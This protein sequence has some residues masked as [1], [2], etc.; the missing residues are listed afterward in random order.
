MYTL[1][2]LAVL[3]ISVRASGLLIW[4][5]PRQVFSFHA[6]ADG[7]CQ[8]VPNQVISDLFGFGDD[9]GIGEAQLKARRVHDIV[10]AKNIW[11]RVILYKLQIVKFDSD[12]DEVAVNFIHGVTLVFYNI[13][14][15]GGITMMGHHERKNHQNRPDKE[16]SEGFQRHSVGVRF[17]RI[18]F[19]L[20]ASRAHGNSEAD[21]RN[22]PSLVRAIRP[23][24]TCN[25][26]EVTGT[27]VPDSV[28]IWGNYCANGIEAYEG[29]QSGKK[30]GNFLGMPNYPISSFGSGQYSRGRGKTRQNGGECRLSPEYFGDFR[31]DNMADNNPAQPAVNPGKGYMP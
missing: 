3:W 26:W 19:S 25:H 6:L 24:I 7:I 30:I 11:C 17:A 31:R 12:L 14:R 1:Q 16:D 2:V 15:G 4:S 21:V 27:S 9:R 13:I 8:A 23:D 28:E 20:R 22:N 10:E 29:L 18:I 5:I